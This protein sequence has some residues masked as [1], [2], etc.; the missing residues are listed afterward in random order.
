MVC[1]AVSN[2]QCTHNYLTNVDHSGIGLLLVN[3]HR[4][5]NKHRLSLKSDPPLEAPNLL[6]PDQAVLTC[7]F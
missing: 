2:S 1:L 6:D 4:F 7:A 3:K 5:V